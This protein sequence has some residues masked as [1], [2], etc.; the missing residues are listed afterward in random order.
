MDEIYK[1]L[2]EA[3]QLATNA[4]ELALEFDNSARACDTYEVWAHNDSG[5]VV[6]RFPKIESAK[7]PDWLENGGGTDANPGHTLLLRLVLVTIQTACN[8]K[9]KTV[10][11]A[12]ETHS[13]LLKAFGLKLA[14]EFLKGT[15][16]SVTAFPNVKVAPDAE[17]R[18]YSFNHAPKLAAIWSQVR[19]TGDAAHGK[20]APTQGIIYMTEDRGTRD[21]ATHRPVEKPAT[22]GFTPGNMLRK[23]LD[24]PFCANLYLNSMAPAL[25]LAMQLGFE[26]DVTQ[27]RIKIAISDI[28]TKTGYHTFR[29]RATGSTTADQLGLLAVQASGSASKLASVDRKSTS[30]QKVLHF[31]TKEL[32]KQG[33]ARTGSA[34]L[35]AQ[36]LL[37]HHVD[38]LEQR[39]EMQVLNTRYTMKR[40]DIQI[41]AVCE[42]QFHCFAYN[43]LKRSDFQH[44]NAGGQPEQST[45]RPRELPR[46]VVHEDTRHC[47]HVL[48]PWKLCLGHVFHAHV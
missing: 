5:K 9:K 29:S 17:L 24:S 39:L 27:S 43:K 44:Y 31:I 36:E 33:F 20:Q 28:E 23:L 2:A 21:T 4:G 6:Q 41:N 46:L 35:N 15:I 34:A 14:N 37:R 40:V 22:A 45:N 38:V 25:L 12:K 10:S 7:V 26:I 11:I 48:P 13:Q 30:I 3:G 42:L 8:T 19:Y 16:T 32:D 47:H 1:K 18:C